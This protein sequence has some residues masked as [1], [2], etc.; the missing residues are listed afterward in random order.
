MTRP[1]TRDRGVRVVAVF[2]G[3]VLSAPLYYDFS[4]WYLRLTIFGWICIATLTNYSAGVVKVLGRKRTEARELAALA[5]ASKLATTLDVESILAG[6]VSLVTELLDPHGCVLYLATEGATGLVPSYKYL[7]P[8]IHTPER[9]AAIMA[10]VAVWGRGLIGTTAEDQTP[11]ISLDISVDPLTVPIPG[12]GIH[13]ETYLLIPLVFDGTTL[14]V[15]RVSRE[16]ANQ[17]TEDDLTLAAIFA[18]Q[19]AVAIAN[20]RLYEKARVA[21]REAR[22]S[23]HRYVRLTRNAGEVIMHIDC[24]D[25]RVTFVN[26]AVEQILGFSLADFTDQPDLVVRSIDDL[27]A[28]ALDLACTRLAEGDE[29]VRD[30]VLTWTSKDGRTVILDHVMIPIRDPEGKLPASRRSHGTSRNGIAW[31][32]QSAS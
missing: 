5:R 3:L 22:V 24:A 27:S 29:S 12:T 19:A 25:R 16:G 18:N 14:G 20:A 9:I 6:T 31:N 21:E 28:A 2:A 15:L 30:V 26:E 32:P 17:Y 1:S 10:S 13:P 4:Y 23:E 11:R 7:D 8:R